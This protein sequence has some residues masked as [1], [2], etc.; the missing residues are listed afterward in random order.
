MDAGL[1]VLVF[2]WRM[3]GSPATWGMSAFPGHP[4]GIPSHDIAMPLGE[5]LLSA[6][7]DKILKREFVVLFLCCIGKW[8]KKIKSFLM[9]EKRGFE[10]PESGQDLGQLVSRVFGLRQCYC[11]TPTIEEGTPLPIFGYFV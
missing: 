9:T 10:A 3:V 1:A 7:R 5:H 2:P 4:F 6:T 11:S 8:R